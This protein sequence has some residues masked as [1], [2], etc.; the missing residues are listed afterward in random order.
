[1]KKASPANRG[2]QAARFGEI[3]Q[4]IVAMAQMTRK[5]QQTQYRASVTAA[6]IVCLIIR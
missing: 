6:R 1:V 2:P 5:A 3:L 4:R